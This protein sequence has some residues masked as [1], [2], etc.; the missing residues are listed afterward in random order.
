MMKYIKGKSWIDWVKAIVAVDIAAVGIGLIFQ[1]ELHILANILG[2]FS[3]VI[4]GVLYL[5]LAYVIFKNTFPLLFQDIHERL[6]EFDTED[7]KTEIVPLEKEEI[8]E[9]E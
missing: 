6:N 2:S 1:E 7:E 3:R 4:F 9:K 5:I 8:S